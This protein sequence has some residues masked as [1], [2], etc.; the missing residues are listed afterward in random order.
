MKRAALVAGAVLVLICLGYS[1]AAALWS[2]DPTVNNLIYGDEATQWYPSVIGDGDGG[3][4]IVWDSGRVPMEDSALYAQR[5]D[6]DGALLWPDDGARL[7]YCNDDRS[8]VTDGAG[9]AIVSTARL[10]GRVNAQR[11]N[12]SGDVLWGLEGTK[13]RVGAG[14]ASWVDSVSD[15]ENGAIIVWCEHLAGYILTVVSQRVDASGALVW[16]PEGLHIGGNLQGVPGYDCTTALRVVCDGAGGAI[17]VWVDDTLDSVCAQRVSGSGELLWGADGIEIGG[18]PLSS[19]SGD[20]LTLTVAGDGAG[21]AVLCWVSWR[22]EYDGL[23][24]QRLDAAGSALWA[25][26]GVQITGEAG[27]FSCPLLVSDGTGGAIAAWT[28]SEETRI[29]RVGSSGGLLWA[30]GGVVVCRQFAWAFDLAA[31]GDGG[32]IL[33]WYEDRISYF[34]DVYAQRVDALGNLRWGVNGALVCAAPSSK[35]LARLATD[36]AGGAIVTWR[37]GRSGSWDIY[38]QLVDKNGRLGHPSLGTGAI[39]GGVRDLESDNALTESPDSSLDGVPIARAL[40]GNYPNPFNPVTRIEFDLPEPAAITLD[41]F[42]VTGRL[43][44]TLVDGYDTAGRKQAF[45]D[46]TDERGRSV[47]SGIYYCRMTAPGYEKTIKMTLLK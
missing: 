40:R 18:M 24:A 23:Y 32:A 17:V 9:G 7:M 25:A 41:I 10:S 27:S 36:C 44:R 15:G 22:G 1:P 46:G 12:A 34:A 28:C 20:G 8:V 33:V 11:V 35:I 2:N 30:D 43:V 31:D 47:A 19:D 13:V 14:W 38:A 29:Q 4:I 16:A 6:G 21:G 37:D 3:A 39:I 45:W 26:D 5:V 42:D